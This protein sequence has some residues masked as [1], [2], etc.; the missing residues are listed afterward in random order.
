VADA[1][2][3]VHALRL[4]CGLKERPA[5]R[6][7]DDVVAVA[8]EDQEWS[9]QVVDA[10]H[11]R[12]GVGNKGRWEKRIVKTAELADAGERREQHEARGRALECEIHRDGAAERLAE[13]KDAR[14]VHVGLLEQAGQGRTS[15]AV[16]RV[17][18]SLTGGYG[19]WAGIGR[20]GRSRVLQREA[21]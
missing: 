21:R 2:E 17:T 16:G 11:C 10:A 13:I 3:D 15:V 7:R 6:E 12:I 20:C 1:K 14:C 18:R 4:W 5:L 19:W 9:A 8:V